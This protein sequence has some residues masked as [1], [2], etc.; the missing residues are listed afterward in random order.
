MFWNTSKF[1]GRSLIKKEKKER[2]S[3]RKGETLAYSGCADV[4]KVVDL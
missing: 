1:V 2:M 3:R 4:E